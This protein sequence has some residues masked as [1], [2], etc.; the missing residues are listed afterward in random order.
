[1]VSIDISFKYFLIALLSYSSRVIGFYLSISSWIRRN[2][3]TITSLQ[4]HLSSSVVG[5]SCFS[6][7]LYL[8]P[9]CRHRFILSRLHSVTFQFHCYFLLK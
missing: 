5:P 7:Y 9:L 1:M 3:H 4:L 8:Y 6:W 2:L